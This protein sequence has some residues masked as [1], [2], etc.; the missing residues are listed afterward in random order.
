[1]DIVT[2][3][4]FW[5]HGPAKDAEPGAPAVLYWFKLTRKGGKA[6]YRTVFIARTDSGIETLAD[7]R[8]RTIAFEDRGSTTAFLLPL[9]MLRRRGIEAVELPSPRRKPPAD[10]IGYAFARGEIN[11]VAWVVKGLAD[12][13]TLSNLDWEDLA[14]TPA[15]MKGNLRVFHATQPIIRSLIVAR[16]GLDGKLKA[17]IEDILLAMNADPAGRNVLEAYNQVARYD[18]IEGEAARRL[19]EVRRLVPLVSEELR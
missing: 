9:A 10:K 14:R 13:G 8:G 6:E 19:E 4:R 1:M 18:R 11:I 15:P 5:A 3:K 17:R 16:R 2:G 7:L 12:A